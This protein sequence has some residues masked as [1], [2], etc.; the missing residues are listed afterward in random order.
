MA[1]QKTTPRG[2]EGRANEA[3]TEGLAEAFNTPNSKSREPHQVAQAAVPAFAVPLALTRI[4]VGRRCSFLYIEY[5]PLCGLEHMHGRFPLRGQNSDPR[6]GL[7]AC[8]LWRARTW[9]RR[10][11]GQ[12]RWICHRRAYSSAGVPRARLPF[13]PARSQSEARL[14]HAAWH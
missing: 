8:A 7:K 9:P 12:R 1:N 2:P 5:C 3:G 10:K 4:V 13:L 6:Q 11:A 14:L